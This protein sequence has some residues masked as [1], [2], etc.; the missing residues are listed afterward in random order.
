MACQVGQDI[1]RAAKLLREG[2]LVAFAT[3]TVYGLGAHALDEQAAA[4]IFAAK[5]RPTFDPL[6]VH[7]AERSQLNDLVLEV[8]DKA[9]ALM[10]ACWPGPL[11]LVLPKTAAVPD[12]VTSGLPSVAVRIPA[13]PVARDL[14]FQVG[15]PIAAPS[16]NLF[17][18]VS[19]TTAEH[20]REQLG[21]RIDYI[22]DGGP[23]SV[24]LESTVVSVNGD[25]VTLLR[26]G[27]TPLEELERIVGEVKS[28][29]PTAQPSETSAQHA[30][31]MLSK[32]YAPGTPLFIVDNLDQAVRRFSASSTG[33]L[34]FGENDG[35]APFA[36]VEQLSSTSD[37]TE[38]AARFFAAVRRLDR[39]DIQ[40]IVAMPFPEEGLG[41]ALNDR[42]RRASI[43]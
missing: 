4:R 12:L 23:C 6:I 26:P 10:D 7:V 37:L 34:L 14:L 32:H 31:G 22:L 40:Q 16:A 25:Q 5:D 9:A 15:L 35:A 20:V 28:T 18:Q 27:G 24:G 42:L 11:T 3:E 2:K 30:P 1:P 41:R 17:G 43:R 38:A 36:T 8:P 21:D 29:F 39:A 13:H 19:P 33:V